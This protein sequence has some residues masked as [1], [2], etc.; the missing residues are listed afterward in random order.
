MSAD[1]SGNHATA[2]ERN[3]TISTNS[4]M[5]TPTASMS[6]IAGTEVENR[7]PPIA[8]C[9]P[10]GRVSRR[11]SAT[12]FRSAFV[13]AET[14][15]AWP[16]NC[17]RM[18]AADSSSDTI[19]V[20]ISLKGSVTAITPSRSSRCAMVS[21]IA[22]AYGSSSTCSPSA[23]TITSCALVPLA[24][25]KLRSSCAMPAWASVPGIENELSVPFMNTARCRRRARA[26]A[27]TRRARA[28]G[29]GTSSGRAH[30][31]GW[32][33]RLRFTD[34]GFGKCRYSAVS[35]T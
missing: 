23:A 31:E 12:S 3:V 10:S 33:Q 13:S 35:D 24:C 6:E 34:E 25:G 14:S 32:T 26:A 28:T 5:S 4:A 11:S 19:P 9:D 15:V 7:S 21:S 17:R 30:R 16:S 8:T 22:V 29:G 1:T 2:N 20:T 18:I 27:A